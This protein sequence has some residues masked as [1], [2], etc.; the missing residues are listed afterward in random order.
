MEL[1]TSEPQV[2]VLPFGAAH[3][4]VLIPQARPVDEGKAVRQDEAK[5]IRDTTAL[6]RIISSPAPSLST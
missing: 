5:P 2:R 6:T 1:R 4:S 3:L